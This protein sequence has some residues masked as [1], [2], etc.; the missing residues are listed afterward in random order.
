METN[1]PIARELVLRE[2]AP[3]PLPADL[4]P[5]DIKAE[6]GKLSCQPAAMTAVSGAGPLRA[7]SARAVV[8][9]AA[10]LAVSAAVSAAGLTFG[11]KPLSTEAALA[12]LLRPDGKLDSILVWTLRLPRS[13][14]AFTGGAG[15][16]CLGLSFA[17][18]DAQPAGGPGLTGVSAGAVAPIVACFVFLPALSSVFYPL[19]GLA[20]GLSAAAVTFGSPVAAMSGPCIWRW[21]HQRVAVSR[22]DHHLHPFS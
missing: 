18:P 12:A 4:P 7:D 10:L 20:G 16:G 15:S 8:L 19:I 2:A 14:A 3:L 6:A 9:M 22:R 5:V 11:T 17:D 21:P 1:G 13:L